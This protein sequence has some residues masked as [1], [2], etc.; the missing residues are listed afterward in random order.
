MLILLLFSFIKFDSPLRC[1]STFTF[2]FMK[3]CWKYMST[4]KHIS[5]IDPC[6]DVH[7]NIRQRRC[8]GRKRKRLT[9]KEALYSM[10]KQRGGAYARRKWLFNQCWNAFC[11]RTLQSLFFS[12]TFL[13]FATTATATFYFS[14]QIFN[15]ESIIKIIR[16]LL[17]F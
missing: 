10:S 6:I 8:E 16:M 7:T 14:S 17:C 11:L 15:V 12:F 4:E 5:C 9:V 3:I 13:T 1:F 2:I